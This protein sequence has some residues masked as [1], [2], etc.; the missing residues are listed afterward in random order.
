MICPLVDDSYRAD[1]LLHVCNA[2]LGEN[3]EAVAGYHLRKSVVYLRVDVVGSSGEHDTGLAVL[4]EELHGLLALAVHLSLERLV[5]GVRLIQRGN[6]L[7]LSEAAV[8]EF[9]CEFLV[10]ALAHALL[11]EYRQERIHELHVPAKL[12]HGILDNLRICSND[13]TVVVVVRAVVLAHFIGHG[14]VEN[15]LHSLVNQ[16][17]DM[18]VRQLR[19]IAYRLGRHGL[20]AAVVNLAGGLRRQLHGESE[21]GEKLVPERIVLVHSEDAWK[22]HY[23]ALCGALRKA[24][25][26]EQQ[27]IFIVEQVRQLLLGGY[28]ARAALAAVVAYVALP[29]REFRDG[30]QAVVGAASAARGGLFDREALQLIQ[31]SDGASLAVVALDGDERAS[32]CAHQ[33]RLVRTDNV[34]AANKLERPQHGVVH[35][36]AALNDYLIAHGG[37][38]A[39]LYDLEQRVLYDRV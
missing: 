30:Q 25:A 24:L 27:V 6:Y 28:V 26:V 31:R 20:N 38:V 17:L 21:L 29:V 32:V 8:R 3:R 16:C 22:S 34:L 4:L 37:G 14:G 12:R 7:F 10:K 9:L 2:V 1:Y 19:R 36:R 18:T 33:S 13:R 23:A 39:Q 35:E 11:V 5:L 15:E